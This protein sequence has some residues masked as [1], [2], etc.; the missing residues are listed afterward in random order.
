MTKSIITFIFLFLFFG[1]KA[2]KIAG[3]VVNSK[4]ETLLGVTIYWKGKI[5]QAVVSDFDGAFSINRNTNDKLLI[6]TYLGQKDSLEVYESETILLSLKEN[7]QELSEVVVSSK[8][9]VIDRLSP[10]HT[11]IITSKTLAKAA[12]CNLSESFETNGSVTVSYSD[13][14][15]GAKQIQLLGLSGLY[16]QTNFENMPL[17]RGLA[18]PFGLNYTPGTW[19]QSIDLAKGVGSVLNG[20]ENMV[21]T[22]NVELKKPDQSERKLINGYVNSFGRLEYNGNFTKKLNKNWGTTF[23]S[24]ASGMISKIDNNADGFLDLPKYGQI[25]VLNRWKYTSDKISFQVGAKMLYDERVGGQSGFKSRTETPLFYGFTNKTIRPE[26]FLKIAKLFPNAP[27]RGLGF[28]VNAVHHNSKSYFGF[29]PYNGVENTF[30]SNLIYQSIIGNSNHTFKTGLSFMWDNFDEKYGGFILK[31]NEAVPGAYFEYAYNNLG[32]TILV[33]G[34]RD[35]Y[36]NL[37]GNKISPRIH[38]KQDIGLN[39]TLRLS[40]G[41]GFRVSNPLADYYGN[42]VSSRTVQFLDKILPEQSS[43]FGGS[44]A[45]DLKK[46]NLN[47]EAYHTEFKNQLI[48]DTE[49]SNYLYFYNLEGKSFTNSFLAEMNYKIASGFD[50]KMA[51]RWVESKQTQGKPFDE[52]VLMDK[53]FLAKDR[54]LFNIAYALPY[55]KW[56]FDLTVQYNGRRRIADSKSQLDHSSYQS[57]KAIYA[58]NFANVNAQVSKN[59]TYFEWYLGGENLNNYK[60]K[61]PIIAANDPFGTKFDA[62]MV[63]G[64]VTGAMIYSGFRYK[65]K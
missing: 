14:V 18:V 56:K 45:I 1:G 30:Y 47:V 4:N 32:K 22:I 52:K 61:D 42:L 43:T 12:C 24:H 29:K 19:V 58:P 27:Y 44:Y 64:P 5:N 20:Y 26:G 9:T 54:I 59:Y 60:Q 11:E 35:D 13:A 41:T 6:Y 57:I 21:G 65:L 62:G 46:L 2:Q 51:Y 25:N 39:Q 8:A 38:F 55:E 15:T 7:T 10:I 37:Y 48:A 31:R 36:H 53:M 17:V 28:I 23:L 50:L 16:V 33:L 34:L 3:K 40:A 63:W 49:H